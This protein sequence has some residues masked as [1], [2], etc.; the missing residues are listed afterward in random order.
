MLVV[1]D[2]TC[3]VWLEEGKEVNECEIVENV[4]QWASG[5][6]NDQVM[7]NRWVCWIDD[8]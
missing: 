7:N 1:G 5:G 8:E 4:N 3:Y 2:F 6:Y